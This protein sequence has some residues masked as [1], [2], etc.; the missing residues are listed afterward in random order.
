[1][2]KLFSGKNPS[3]LFTA[4]LR[5]DIIRITETL[6]EEIREERN[7]VNSLLREYLAER[8]YKAVADACT[9]WIKTWFAENGPSSPAVI[10]ISGGKDSTVVAALCVQALGKERVFGVL[11]P[12][13]F[14]SDMDVSLQV[15]KTLDIP[16]AVINIR[17]SVSAV[18]TALAEG[19]GRSDFPL[20]MLTNLPPRL[21]MTTLYAVSQSMNG[22]VSN[23]CNRSEN[24]VGYSTIFGDAAGDFSPLANL[25]VAEIRE[26]GRKMHLPEEFLVKAPSDGLSGRTDEEAFGFSYETLDTY[27]L[28][29]VCEDADVRAAIIRRHLANQFKRKPMPE[30]EWNHL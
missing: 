28:T 22:R 21:R 9:A 1:M 13:G 26:V 15:V 5:N 16:H 24:Y 23:N 8:D 25:T 3:L 20:Q 19:L 17:E 4:A 30:F 14:Q 18:Q 6:H 27:I 10:G 7:G 29:G 12:D 11:M 2:S